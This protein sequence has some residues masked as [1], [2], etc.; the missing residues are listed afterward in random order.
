MINLE[1][2]LIYSI[3]ITLA[4]VLGTIFILGWIFQI[5]LGELGI[6]VAMFSVIIFT[7]IYYSKPIENK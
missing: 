2:K 4:I 1:K 5:I 3:L 7:I 6:Y